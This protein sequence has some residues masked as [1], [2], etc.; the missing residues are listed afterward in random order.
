MNVLEERLWLWDLPGWERLFVFEA[1]AEGG[2][3]GGELGEA[4]AEGI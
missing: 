3:G 1:T 2:D 4:L